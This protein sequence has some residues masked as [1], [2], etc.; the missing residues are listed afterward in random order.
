[1]ALKYNS[2]NYHLIIYTYA[3]RRLARQKFMTNPKQKSD[4]LS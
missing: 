2:N 4:L 1:M 3:I